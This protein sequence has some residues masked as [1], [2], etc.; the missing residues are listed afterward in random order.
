MLS[1]FAQQVEGEVGIHQEDA[2][3]RWQSH[4]K[5]QIH[6]DANWIVGSFH[7]LLAAPGKEVAPAVSCPTTGAQ[8]RLKRIA[9]VLLQPPRHVQRF[10]MQNTDDRAGDEMQRKGTG[11]ASP[12]NASMKFLI[13]EECN[14]THRR[15]SRVPFVKGCCGSVSKYCE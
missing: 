4:T 6:G 14:R 11:S 15:R 8:G 7:C 13:D 5:V 2:P 1:I 9:R 10:E 12:Q 3:G